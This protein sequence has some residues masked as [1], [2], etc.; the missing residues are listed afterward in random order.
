VVDP[1]ARNEACRSPFPGG[2][3]AVRSPRWM[4]AG[5][6]KRRM[7]ASRGWGMRRA[8]GGSCGGIASISRTAKI[9]RS[10]GAPLRQNRRTWRASARSILA[11][12]F[13]SRWGAP[14][15]A[16]SCT[17]GPDGGAAPSAPE[18]PT[19]CA[20][21]RSPCSAPAGPSAGPRAR[22]QASGSFSSQGSTA[23]CVDRSLT[24][25]RFACSNWR[26]RRCVCVSGLT[27]NSRTSQRQAPWRMAAG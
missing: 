19:N 20:R 6:S 27:G 18:V 13:C 17:C 21:T 24:G 11:A 26:R 12:I 10:N 2:K 5:A 14:A 9:C 16:D 15:R 7:S 23:G 1:E 25:A 3:F 4:M 8:S 22:G